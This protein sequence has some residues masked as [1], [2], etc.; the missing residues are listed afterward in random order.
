MAFDRPIYYFWQAPDILDLMPP[1]SKRWHCNDSWVRATDIYEVLSEPLLLPISTYS[2]GKLGKCIDISRLKTFRCTIDEAKAQSLTAVEHFMMALDQ[3]NIDPTRTTLKLERDQKC[4]WDILDHQTTGSSNAL[5]YLGLTANCI[6]LDFAVRYRLE[7]CVSRGYLREY[8]LDAV[9]LEKLA[10]LDVAKASRM[11]DYIADQE[12][13]VEDPMQIFEDAKF[14]CAPAKKRI[15]H[16]CSLVLKVNITPTCLKLNLPN[17]ESSNRVMRKY[18][19]LHDRFLRVQFLSET[20]SDRIAKDRYN[21]DDV[22]KRLLRA[23]HKGI[24]IGDR[25]YEFLAFGNSQLREGSVTFF[26]PTAYLSCDD[27]R[28]WLGNFDHIRNIAKFGARIGQCFSTTR[29][30]RGIRVPTVR[31]IDDIETE[32]E[33]FSDGVGIISG[34]L[35]KLVVDEMK[36]DVVGEPSA[37]QFRMG[38]AKGVLAVWPREYAKHME[39]CVRKSQIKFTTEANTLEIVK[40]AKTTTATLNRQ[41]IIILEHLGVSCGAFL[42]LL[43]AHI[44]QYEE[45]MTDR[46]AAIDL[47]TKFVDENQT[48]VIIAELL[49]ADFQDPFVKNLLKLWRSWSLKLMKEKCRIHVEKS[50]FVMGC[51]DE[52]GTLQGHSKKTEGSNTKRMDDL[53]QIFLQISNR[54]YRNKTTIIKGLCLIGRNP[55]LHAGDIRVVQA[56]DMQCLRHLKDVVV[57]PSK[58]DRSLPSMLSGG[59]LDGDDYFVIW[60]PTLMPKVWNTPPMHSEPVNPQNLDRD[61]EVND[62]RNFVVKYMKNDFLGLIAYSHLA[63]ADKKGVNSPMCKC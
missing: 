26:C 63:H 7:V 11:L 58:G 50:A 53:P 45:A 47:L 30:V 10:S 4:M 42:E 15:P 43:N 44:K 16:Y 48:T 52:T 34:L 6:Y 56:V 54:K 33:C 31:L 25:T 40:C 27:I 18:N 28:K 21:N 37:F 20:E 35:G 19:N 24:R 62:L 55:S 61:V 12:L 17:V 5:E 38:G 51:V 49:K 57:F 14:L 41:T 60:E 3:Y 32:G 22:W 39:V 29:E 8:A 13:Q 1:D 46:T 59:D 9:F 36:L 23:L 2:R